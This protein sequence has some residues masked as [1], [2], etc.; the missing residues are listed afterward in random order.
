[1]TDD[2]NTYVATC[3]DCNWHSGIYPEESRA[4]QAGRNHIHDDREADDDEHPYDEDD[5]HEFHLEAA[6][7]FMDWPEQPF[8]REDD[9]HRATCDTCQWTSGPYWDRDYAEYAEERHLEESGGWDGME[10]E[11][12]RP[13]SDHDTSVEPCSWEALLDT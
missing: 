11:F 5:A 4:R 2:P 7:S 1:M 10:M 8:R 12:R 13:N 9:A 6:G 3:D